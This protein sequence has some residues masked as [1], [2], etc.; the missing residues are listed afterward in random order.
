MKGL[1]SEGESFL[2]VSFF[3]EGLGGYL[4]SVV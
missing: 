2:A 3:C 4:E 1:Q